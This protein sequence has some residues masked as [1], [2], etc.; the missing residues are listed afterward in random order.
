MNRR[1][2]LLGAPAV[3]KAAQ[4]RPNVVL[5]MADDLGSSDL[6]SYGCPDIRTPHIDSIG[7]HG[8]RF[9]RCYANAP[10]CTPTRTA[11]MTGRYQHRVGGLECAIGV[12]NVGRYDEA[13]WLQ[14]RDELGLPEAETSMARMLKTAGYEQPAPASGISATSISS[15]RTVMASMNRSPF[16]AA[17]R[18]T[19]RIPKK[20]ER[21]C[22]IT[23]AGREAKRL[24]HRLDRRTCHRLAP[25][26]HEEALLS[27]CAIHRS[28]HAAARSRRR[29]G[30]GRRQL[31]CRHARDLCTDGRAD[32]PA[33]GRDSVPTGAHGRRAEYDSDFQERQRRL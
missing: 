19:L 30:E 28:A 20:T 23:T 9:T 4:A 17:T 2:F 16:S 5:I 21:T 15:R 27:L 24:S 29:S 32:G 10:E 14:K 3:L 12:G 31:E 11:L 8:V 25:K 6:S 1:T 7:K 26:A 22:C 18:T 33:G 13:E